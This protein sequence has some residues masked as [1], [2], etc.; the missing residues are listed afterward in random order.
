MLT[1]VPEIWHTEFLLVLH[2]RRTGSR[3]DEIGGS[4]FWLHILKL[5]W[6]IIETD[7]KVFFSILILI[8]FII[9]LVGLIIGGSSIAAVRCKLFC[10]LGDW[11]WVKWFFCQQLLFVFVRKEFDELDS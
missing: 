11:Y 5:Q 7:R 4:G 3:A 9:I 8:F 6:V 10:F 1:E 2:P